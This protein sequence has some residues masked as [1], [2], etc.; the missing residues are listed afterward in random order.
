M[1]GRFGSG[2]FVGGQ[3]ETVYSSSEHEGRS[4]ASIEFNVVEMDSN[5]EVFVSRTLFTLEDTIPSLGHLCAPWIDGLGGVGSISLGHSRVGENAAWP[6]KSS[7]CIRG[8]CGRLK[9][10][11]RS[12][13]RRRAI[14]LRAQERK[15][16]SPFAEDFWS[17][18]HLRG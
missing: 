7:G 5:R 6:R 2:L 11:G 10:E 17:S 16:P 13:G 4:V 1:R 18:S 12:E 8:P 15:L 9:G 3:W 14:V